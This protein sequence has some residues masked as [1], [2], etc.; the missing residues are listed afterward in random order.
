[1]SG[2]RRSPTAGAW[3]ARLAGL[4][5]WSLVLAVVLGSAACAPRL[6]RPAKEWTELFDQRSGWTGADGIFSFSLGGGGGSGA[7]S[8][9]VT[10]FVFSDTAIGEVDPAGVRRVGT[11]IVNNTL[12]CLWGNEPEGEKLRFYWGSDT[13]GRPAAMLVPS[14][15]HARPGEWYW[16]G[17]GLVLR[18]ELWLFAYRLRSTSEAGLFGFATSGISLIRLP[19]TRCPPP[20]GEQV[21]LE[22]PFFIPATG[23]RSQVLFGA[24][25]MANT[26]AAQAPH[27]DGYIYVYGVEDDPWNKKLLA[28]RVEPEHFGDFSAW[29][30]WNGGQWV[31]DAV[32]A[33]PI[34]DR[35]GNELSVTPLSDGRY[36]LV[37]QLDAIGHNVAVR[38]GTS[39]VGPFGP[40]IPIW[41]A[42]EPSRDLDWF[43]YNAKAHPHLSKSGKLLISYH[44]NSFDFWGDFP[45]KAGIYQP[46]F[47]WLDLDQLLKAH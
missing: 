28:A 19:A 7:P 12:A 29:R 46:R 24:G 3:L 32:H 26:S 44:V 41:Q 42:P 10:L 39:P 27:P 38:L 25:L 18:G 43:V 40:P 16:L 17:S 14:T 1:M 20:I 6:A 37:F 30:F 45:K 33:A 13:H 4:G 35:V 31:E 34:T 8:N 36:L 22:T 9:A 47:I 5:R 11:V 21:Q 15:P 2:A 23:E